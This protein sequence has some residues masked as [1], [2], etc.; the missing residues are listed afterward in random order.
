M[1]IYRLCLCLESELIFDKLTGS[2]Y[3]LDQVIII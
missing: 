3:D 1:E 2:G